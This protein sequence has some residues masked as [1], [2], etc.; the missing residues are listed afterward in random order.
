LSKIVGFDQLWTAFQRKLVTHK[1]KTFLFKMPNTF[2]RFA[3]QN[4]YIFTMK[5]QA[6][7]FLKGDQFLVKIFLNRMN[8]FILYKDYNYSR[9]KKLKI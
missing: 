2:C 9:Y 5:S 6:F 8:L 1:Q 4:C 7:Q 3:V